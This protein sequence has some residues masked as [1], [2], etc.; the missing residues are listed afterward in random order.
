MTVQVEVTSFRGFWNSF[1]RSR[2]GV[3]GLVMVIVAL[4][5]AVFAPGLL[6]MTPKRPCG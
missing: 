3:V 2:M 5:M 6:L 1:K 4:A